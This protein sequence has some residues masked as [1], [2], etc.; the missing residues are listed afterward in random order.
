MHSPRLLSHIRG[1]G[2]GK[3]K[4]RVRNKE[5]RREGKDVKG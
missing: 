3:G 2:G 1:R 4:E 5:G